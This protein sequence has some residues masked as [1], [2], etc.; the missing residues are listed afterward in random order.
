MGSVA[1]GLSTDRI[2]DAALEVLDAD[3]IDGLT[4]RA[5]AERLGVRPPALYWH[6]RDKRQL[7]D[8]MATRVW[9]DIARTAERDAEDGDGSWADAFRAY[10]RAARRGLLAHRDGARLFGGT[11]LTDSALLE[12]QEPGLARLAA[13]G[14]GPEAAADAFGLVTSFAVGHSIEEQERRTAPE[15]YTVEARERR[16]DPGRFP[17]VT[18]TGRRMLGTDPDEHFERLLDAVIVAVGSLRGA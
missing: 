12:H 1:K 15:R 14:F 6:L 5:V 7:V 13:L 17:L 18:A 4:V 9:R 8:E 11:F 10:A 3:G 2:V 16:I